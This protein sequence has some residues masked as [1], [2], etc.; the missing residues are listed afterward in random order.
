MYVDVLKFEEW[1]EKNHERYQRM[2]H[3][4]NNPVERLIRIKNMFT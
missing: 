4:Y 2:K 1:H 3:H